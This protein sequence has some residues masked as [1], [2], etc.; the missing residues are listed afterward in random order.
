MGKE[1]LKELSEECIISLV[2]CHRDKN[3]RGR[4]DQCYSPQLHQCYSPW[5]DQCYSSVL[6][7]K[8]KK[9]HSPGVRACWP[10]R[11]EEERGPRPNFGSSFY[12]LFLLPLGMPCVNWASQECSLFYLRC[13]LWSSNL[14]LFYFHGLFP[15]LSFS[16]CYSGLLFHI[17]TTSHSPLKR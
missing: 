8:E 9:T 10:K 1:F 5:M 14:P 6:L 16:H 4:T 15:S 13:S 17:L 12:M 3:L 2:L 11:R 7:R